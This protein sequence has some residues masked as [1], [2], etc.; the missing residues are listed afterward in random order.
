VCLV[1]PSFKSHALTTRPPRLLLLEVFSAAGRKYKARDCLN[2][3]PKCTETRLRA[4]VSSKNF[5]GLY[6]DPRFKGRGGKAKGRV[7]L[8]GI[9]GREWE[10]RRKMKGREEGKGRKR[11]RRE[12]SEGWCPPN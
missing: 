11:D 7:G 8:E 12:D 10:G 2:L 4:F 5:P 9:E 6:P 3:C 1:R